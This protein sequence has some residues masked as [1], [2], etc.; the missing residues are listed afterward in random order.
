MRRTRIRCSDWGL[1]Y[2]PRLPT[3]FCQYFPSRVRLAPPARTQRGSTNWAG[4]DLGLGCVRSG[5]AWF[6]CGFGFGL[7]WWEGGR[8]KKVCCQCLGHCRNHSMRDETGGGRLLHIL[9]RESEKM[10]NTMKL[11]TKL[12]FWLPN[13][14]NDGRSD[15]GG[16]MGFP[17]E[18]CCARR[19]IPDRWHLGRMQC[20]M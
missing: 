20:A 9:G 16:G 8:A 1:H 18:R 15:G 12:H 3:S 5:S 17:L 2:H 6:G 11:C 19:L 10:A 14:T 13:L 7:V 4:F